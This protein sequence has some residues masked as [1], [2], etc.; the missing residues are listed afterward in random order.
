MKG[1]LNTMGSIQNY[2]EILNIAQKYAKTHK[3]CTFNDYEYFKSML[4]SMNDYGHEAE[5]ADILNI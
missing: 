1:R 2:K 5:L 3:P 4:H